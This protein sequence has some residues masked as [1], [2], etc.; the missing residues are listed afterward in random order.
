[1][2]TM[3]KAQGPDPAVL[4]AIARLQRSELDPLEEVMFQ[5]WAVANQIDDPETGGLDLRKI[6]Q[7]TGG[8]V[9]PPGQL[10]QTVEKAAAMD[11]VKKAQEAH[12]QAS[13][14]KLLMENIDLQQNPIDSMTSGME[15]L[16]A[17]TGMGGGSEFGY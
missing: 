16:G 17:D 13:P 15:G 11:T 14:M 6:Y 12:D 4:E 2:N 3:N 10:K 9:L 8:K 1:M 5:S 7:Q